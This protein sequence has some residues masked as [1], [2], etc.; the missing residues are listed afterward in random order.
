MNKR[1]FITS[2]VMIILMAL[3]SCGGGSFASQLRIILAASGPLVDSLPISDNL[4][5]GLVT[6]FTDLAS[7]A[8]DLSDDLKACTDNPCKLDAVKKFEVRFWDIQRR[9]HFKVNPKIQRIQ[10][11]IEGIIDSAKIYFGGSSRTPRMAGAQPAVVTDADIKAQL[12][13]LKE[14]MKP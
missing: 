6:D 8:A 13:E 9:G 5:K 3:A 4:R 11:I 10:S 14:A 1:N 12:D 2:G 7:G